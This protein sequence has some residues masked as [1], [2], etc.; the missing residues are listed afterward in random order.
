MRLRNLESSFLENYKSL[1]KNMEDFYDKVVKKLYP[2]IWLDARTQKVGRVHLRK[3]VDY[4]NSTIINIVDKQ[5]GCDNY[6]KLL[7]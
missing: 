7:W 3:S 2:T 1:T 4:L 5:V 6:L